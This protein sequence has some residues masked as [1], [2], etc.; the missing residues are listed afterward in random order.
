MVAKP[1][2]C[3]QQS[4]MEGEM[5]RHA[6]ISWLSKQ[7]PAQQKTILKAHGNHTRSVVSDCYKRGWITRDPDRFYSVTDT[8]LK[9]LELQAEFH[10]IRIRLDEVAE[11]LRNLRIAK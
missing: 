11:E 3:W 10:R 7:P 4:G 1:A 5:T 6:L 2:I 8:G 9:V